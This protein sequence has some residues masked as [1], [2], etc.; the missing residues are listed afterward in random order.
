MQQVPG[1]AR[2]RLGPRIATLAGGLH[3]TRGLVGHG[4]SDAR[5][6]GRADRARR[7]G[8]RCPTAHSSITSTRSTRRTPC[9]CATGP[10]A[11][12]RCTPSRPARCSWP[13]CPHRRSSACWPSRASASR[14]RPSPMPA[15]SSTGC[16]TCART[17]TPGCARSSR[18]ASRRSPRPIASAD[19]E[20][21]AAVHVHGPSYRFPTPG[22]EAKVASA[23]VAAAA[24]VGM[25][26]RA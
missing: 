10:A 5:R 11:G 14:R 13:S 24:E 2:Y 22:S 3:E 4:T 7:P 9:R 21:I 18:M 17:A 23:V 20:V 16:A 1:D 26:L 6:A 8:C 19:G 12:S 25:R 15:R